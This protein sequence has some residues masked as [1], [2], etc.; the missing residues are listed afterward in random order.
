MRLVSQ[1]EI[2][3]GTGVGARSRSEIVGG[4]GAGRGMGVIEAGACRGWGQSRRKVR[5]G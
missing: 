5:V 4:S 2:G 3:G 1:S